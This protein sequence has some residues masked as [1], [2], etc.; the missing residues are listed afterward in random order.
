MEKAPRVCKEASKLALFLGICPLKMNQ[1]F[2]I[3][4]LDGRV[5]VWIKPNQQMLRICGTLKHGGGGVMVWVCMSVAS[6]RNL[7]F[8]EEI[9]IVTCIV[10]F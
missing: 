10:I 5:M 6:I 3:H 2:N 4:V 1:K 7:C 8:I 9:W